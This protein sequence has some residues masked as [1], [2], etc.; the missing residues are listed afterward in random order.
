V[1]LTFVPLTPAHFPLLLQWLEAPHVKAWWDRDLTYDLALVKEKFGPRAQGQ[2][3]AK[4]KAYV[5][6]CGGVAMG[7]VQ[8]YGAEEGLPVP[9]PSA[10][11]D[12]FI[13]EEKFLNLG[14]GPLILEAF[15]QDILSKDFA[16]CVVDPETRNLKALGAYTRAGFQILPA[17]SNSQT[18]WML[19]LGIILSCST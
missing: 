15:W 1:T 19:K 16:S 13:G 5:V 17:L 11:M 6:E 4:I 8:M 2:A 7:Y 14:L 18:T 9:Q 10:G 12:I 3:E